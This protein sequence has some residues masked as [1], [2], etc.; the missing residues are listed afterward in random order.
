MPSL[1][2]DSFI[3]R[4]KLDLFRLGTLD[5]GTRGPIGP[6]LLRLCTAYN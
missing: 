2:I 6:F 4:V 3:Y 5:K 1:A